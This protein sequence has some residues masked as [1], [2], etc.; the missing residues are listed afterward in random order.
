VADL[1]VLG[2][3]DRD[4]AEEVF[5]LGTEL[6]QAELVDLADGALAWREEDGKVRIQQAINVTGAS[7]HSGALWGTLIAC[8]LQVPLVGLAAGAT[9][10]AIAGR[11]SDIGIGE[12]VVKE[13]TAILGPGRA[14]VF[15]LVRR[16]TPDR[17]RDAIRPYRPAVLHAS[18]SKDTDEELVRALQG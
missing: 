17:V 6:R 15:A 5:R 10:G 2:F 4:L 14:A 13:I 9:S 7:A 16:S 11:L 8:I 3:D 1:M 12:D 18:L